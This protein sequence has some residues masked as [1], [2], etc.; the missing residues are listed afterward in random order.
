[1]GPRKSAE[2]LAA[3]ACTRSEQLAN[4]EARP[5]VLVSVTTGGE[6]MG[7]SPAVLLAI[8]VGVTAATQQPHDG[9][10][11]PAAR[12]VPAMLA[13]GSARWVRSPVAACSMGGHS[14]AAEGG[15]VRWGAAPGSRAGLVIQASAL[16]QRSRC[17]GGPYCPPCQRSRSCPG[18]DLPDARPVV[19]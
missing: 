7:R 16:R 17:P 6:R 12:A 13:D 3:Q 9:G 19:C 18:P 14:Q 5:A 8:A 2:Y 1:M 4:D 11:P 15:H 10:M